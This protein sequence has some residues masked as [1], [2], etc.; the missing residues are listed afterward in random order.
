M[1]RC[2]TCL[3]AL[4]ASLALPCRAEPPASTPPTSATLTTYTELY[5]GSNAR[6]LANKRYGVISAWKIERFTPLWSKDGVVFRLNPTRND[7]FST[8]NNAPTT[9]PVY[10]TEIRKRVYFI[11]DDVARRRVDANNGAP[12]DNLLVALDSRAQGRLVWTRRANDFAAFFESDTSAL[13]FAPPL[14]PLTD[15]ELTIRVQNDQEVK[16]FAINAAD[17]AFRLL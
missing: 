8:L 17:G 12:R 3:I 6:W 9:R 5:Q 7:V 11:L 13:R 4:V 10:A 16:E 1:K 14:L 15:D 2:R